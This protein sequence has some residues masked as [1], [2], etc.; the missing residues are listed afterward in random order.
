MFNNYPIFRL[1][2]DKVEI[3]IYRN[4]LKWALEKANGFNELTSL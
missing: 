1:L 3:I 2:G 4:I